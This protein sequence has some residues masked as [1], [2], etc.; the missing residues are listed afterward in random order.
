MSQHIKAF[1]LRGC[2]SL[3]ALSLACAL[4][5]PLMAQDLQP[6]AS[7][8]PGQTPSD[9]ALAH[10]FAPKGALR[11]SINVGNPILASL[12]SETDRPEGVSVDLATELAQRL[13]VPL[14]LVTVKS[15]GSSVKNLEQDKADVGFF[16]IDPERGQAIQFT[17]AYLTIEGVYA[18]PE[19]SAIQ[20]LA[21]LDQPGTTVAVSKG[22]AYDLFLSR[23]LHQATI[24]R[25]ATAS[26]VVQG[27][28]DQHLNAAAG[29]RQ[30]VEK[31][32]AQAGNLRVIEPHFMIIR[33]AMGVPKTRGQAVA[34]YLANFVREMKSSGFVAAS[35]ARHH[36]VGASVASAED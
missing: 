10:L 6:V 30:Q 12:P 2:P 21:Q 25:L 36:V 34:D 1:S 13:G 18:V 24:V 31:D 35:L 22:S 29:I 9:A 19:N 8:Q 16:A 15:A 3:I 5:G 28:L 4:S 7:V 33:Q 17:P 14:E 20:T 32:V 26:G 11:V 27:F 23:E